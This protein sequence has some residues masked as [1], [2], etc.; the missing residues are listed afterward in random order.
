M[1][2]VLLPPGVNPIAVKYISYIKTKFSTGTHYDHSECLGDVIGI[3][4][5]SSELY[6]GDVLGQQWGDSK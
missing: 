1:C 5:Q 2:A 4:G 3:F 6:L